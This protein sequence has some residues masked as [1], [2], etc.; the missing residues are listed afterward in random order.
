MLTAV[1]AEIDVGGHVRLLEPLEVTKT[2]RA[3]VTL[4]EGKGEK[5]EGGN[6]KAILDFLRENRLPEGS[7]LTAEEIEAQIEENRNSWD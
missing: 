6:I 7:R 4:L 5:R 2:T 1:E 3:V